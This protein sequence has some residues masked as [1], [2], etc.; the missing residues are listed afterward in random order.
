[1]KERLVQNA[2]CKYMDIQYPHV[3]YRTDKDGQFAKGGAL[4]DKA[5]QKG[6]RGFPDL[7][8]REQV[9]EY[10]GLIIELKRDGETVWKKDGTLRKSG[11]LEEQ[12]G[13]LEWFKSMG[14]YT[15]FAIG[16]DAGKDL[17]DRYLKGQL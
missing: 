15:D 17:I 13:W 9:G 11:H 6:E 14:C 4:W 10:K 8:I 7:I 1:M 5:R 16:F 2:L 12:F 3:K